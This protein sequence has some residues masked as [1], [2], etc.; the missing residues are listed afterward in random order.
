MPQIKLVLAGGDDKE[1]FKSATV[2]TRR[3]GD[4]GDALG[5]ELD[6]PVGTHTITITKYQ[7]ASATDTIDIAATDSVIELT[8][9]KTGCTVEVS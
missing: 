8:V 2:A 7:G 3:W 9:D 5:T 1:N 6:V 4:N